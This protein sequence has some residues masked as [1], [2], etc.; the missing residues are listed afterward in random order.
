MVDWREV[1]EPYRLLSDAPTHAVTHTCLHMLH[2]QILHFKEHLLMVPNTLCF[3]D[4][5]A[6]YAVPCEDHRTH[7]TS[8]L[9]LLCL[10][11]L[12]TLGTFFKGTFWKNLAENLPKRRFVRKVENRL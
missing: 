9:C 12:Y 11:R 10:V 3:H 5:V 8:L 4:L 6:F 2:M 7:L 1:T